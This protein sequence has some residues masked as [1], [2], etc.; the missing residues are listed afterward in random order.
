M[1]C[2][3]MVDKVRGEGSQYFQRTVCKTTGQPRE[4]AALPGALAYFDINL[5]PSK[6]FPINEILAA[7]SLYPMLT[8]GACTAMLSSIY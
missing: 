1:K 6:V 5:L 8:K 7:T 2:E 4:T 3:S